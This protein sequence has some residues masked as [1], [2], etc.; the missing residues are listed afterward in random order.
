MSL[1]I[2]QDPWFE[3]DLE[4]DFCIEG[5]KFWRRPTVGKSKLKYQLAVAKLIRFFYVFLTMIGCLIL[6]TAD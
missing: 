2:Q 6:E 4:Y 3:I 5:I 1:R